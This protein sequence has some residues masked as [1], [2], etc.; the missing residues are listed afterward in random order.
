M[1]LHEYKPLKVD[2][3]AA[4]FSVLFQNDIVTEKIQAIQSLMTKLNAH[5]QVEAAAISFSNAVSSIAYVVKE[6]K[7][8]NVGLL[9][10]SEFLNVSVN[11]LNI[12]LDELT[13]HEECT[14]LFTPL[15]PVEELMLAFNKALV[16]TCSTAITI[17]LDHDLLDDGWIQDIFYV[18]TERNVKM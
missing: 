7:Q 8:A 11:N 10:L 15:V 9:N 17:G 1:W 6:Q 13:N 3:F 2:K 12:S 18:K 4:E 5:S 14:N 16:Q